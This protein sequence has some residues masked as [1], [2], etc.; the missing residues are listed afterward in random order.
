MSDA[1]DVPAVTAALRTLIESGIQSTVG[2]EDT[3]VT[4]QHPS[5]ARGERTSN[6][7]NA[8]L[9]RIALDPT[10]RKARTGTERLR[11][12]LGYLI[13]AYGREGDDLSEQGLLSRVMEIL[14]ENPVLMPNEIRIDV[15]PLSIE[16]LSNLWVALETPCR[17]AVA[18]QLRL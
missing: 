1:I 10:L 8:Y 18:Y 13:T 12:Q 2:L 5:T 14:D 9:Y 3:E 16:E 7:V 17:L 15:Q 11:M 6:Q 4:V